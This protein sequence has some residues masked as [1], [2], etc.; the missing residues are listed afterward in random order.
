MLRVDQA[1]P[2]QLTPTAAELKTISCYRLR[3]ERHREALSR[4]VAA[5]PEAVAGF[6]WTEF[7]H[8]LAQEGFAV[9]FLDHLGVTGWIEPFL[10]T[11]N[12][13]ALEP[14]TILATALLHGADQILVAHNHP[15][16]DTTPSP[17]DLLFTRRL[18]DACEL[19]GIV[20]VDSLV[21]A[22]GRERRSFE[23]LSL[24]RRQLQAA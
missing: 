3:L 13:I 20:L 18:Q 7:F 22:H 23:W 5:R 12:R 1:E 11:V 19:L 2:Q 16:G 14:R 15:S 9:V 10:G 4:H 6:L 17:E 24:R 8:D 21:L